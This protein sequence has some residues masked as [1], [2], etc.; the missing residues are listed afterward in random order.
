MESSTLSVKELY[1]A[2][3]EPELEP[4]VLFDSGPL[5][6]NVPTHGIAPIWL[7]EAS[8][9][10]RLQEAR[11]LLT[12]FGEAFSPRVEQKHESR[13]PLVG[14]PP[15]AHLAPEQPLSFPS[16]IWSLACTIWSIIARRNIFEGSLATQD[17]MTCEHVEALG[18]LPREW[19]IKW[20]SRRSRFTED[21]TPVGRNPYRSW[22]DRFE[23]SVQRPR[24]KFE[25]PRIALDERDALLAM[26]KL[27]LSFRPE[28]RP[29]AKQVLEL[30]W[31]VKWA[32]PEYNKIKDSGT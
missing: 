27:M 23:D 20:E 5:P 31:M 19:W 13:T 25:M 4:V 26:L 11:I 29:T 2:Y 22:L 6:S 9:D 21:G 14:R 24:E 7:G 1:D 32:L 3:G 8:E 18:I 10:I 28:E 17:D 16:D 30:E 15:E 12:D